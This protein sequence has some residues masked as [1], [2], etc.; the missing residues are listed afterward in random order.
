VADAQRPSMSVKLAT[1][2][3]ALVQFVLAYLV[4]LPIFLLFKLAR[5]LLRRGAQ[6]P[7]RSP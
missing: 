3:V 7:P 4:A 2:A 5:R 6:L 1:V